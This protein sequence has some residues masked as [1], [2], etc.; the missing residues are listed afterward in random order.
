[1]E[2]PQLFFSAELDWQKIVLP[3]TKTD[4]EIEISDL[5][6][7][8]LINYQTAVDWITNGI[9]MVAYNFQQIFW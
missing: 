1:M 4:A 8:R 7:K 5:H 3:Y 6:S 9:L 2:K